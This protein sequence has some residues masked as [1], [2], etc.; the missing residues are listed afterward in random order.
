MPCRGWAHKLFAKGIREH[1][2]GIDELQVAQFRSPISQE[3]RRFSGRSDLS[4]GRHCPW[5][6]SRTNILV[7]VEGA[8]DASDGVSQAGRSGGER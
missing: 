7:P 8:D 2:H 3:T 4:A 1:L 6:R 5:H